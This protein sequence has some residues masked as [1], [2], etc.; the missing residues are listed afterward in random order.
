MRY[1]YATLPKDPSNS[2]VNTG[3][4]AGGAQRRGVPPHDGAPRSSGIGFSVRQPW[5]SLPNFPAWKV[6]RKYFLAPRMGSR[7]SRTLRRSGTRF[8]TQP[9]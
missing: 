5:P 7:Q 4:P 2:S 6:Y 8:A 1:A 9:E 3:C